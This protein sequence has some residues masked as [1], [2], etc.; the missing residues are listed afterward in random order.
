MARLAHQVLNVIS[1]LDPA[2]L[3]QAAQSGGLTSVSG[4]I[5]LGERNGVPVYEISGLKDQ[6]LLGF[7][8]ITTPVK[9]IVSTE[10]GQTVTQ[11]Q[12]LLANIAVFQIP[13][14]E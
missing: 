9:V 8:P 10:T 11:E 14:E 7:I 4:V 3:Q 5:T 1:R 6:R 13:S 12:S 2:F